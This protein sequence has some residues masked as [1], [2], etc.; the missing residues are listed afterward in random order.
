MTS[1]EEQFAELSQT[2]GFMLTRQ[3]VIHL[4]AWLVAFSLFAATDSW[5]Q[6]TGWSLA[7]LLN[8]L[9]GIAAGFLTVNLVHEWFHYAGARLAGAEYGITSSFSL[10]VFDW[11]FDKNTLYQ[12]YLMS[13]AGSI[14]GMVA[15]CALFSAVDANSAGRVA[16]L[17]GGVASFA[18]GS[19][20]EWPVLLRTRRSR[21]PLAELSKLTPAALAKAAAGSALAG[22]LCW[23][24]LG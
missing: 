2:R 14:G 3:A 6:L 22:L 11:Q 1:P 12:F 16:L 20:V 23:M 9:T 13:I 10:F 24:L 7:S 15:V 4:A 21:D 8:V 5:S 17:S 19:I 18:F